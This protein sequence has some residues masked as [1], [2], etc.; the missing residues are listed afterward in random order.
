M[1]YLLQ[2]MFGERSLTKVAGIYHRQADA[3]AS[4]EQ[5]R[6]SAGLEGPQVR[7]L[8]PQDASESHRD[9]FGTAI[10]PESAGL[11]RTLVQT[12]VVGGMAGAA[13]GL[14]IFLWL[15]R[16]G[17]AFIASSPLLAFL[18]I[19]GF[20]TVFGLLAA[21]LIA[22]RPDHILL[23]SELRSAL[24]AKRWVVVA[25]PVNREQ[26]ARI[27]ELLRATQAEVRSTL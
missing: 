10:E 15:S 3:E 27:K 18:A 11:A 16:A 4:L 17:H 26:T 25:H 14:A 7:L 5:L 6:N 19:V 1:D 8:G 20:A 24:R 9:L 12:H 2:G 21:G 23:I 13:L 22:L